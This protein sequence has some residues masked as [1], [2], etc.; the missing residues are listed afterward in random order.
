L[1]DDRAG[2]FCAAGAEHGNLHG[3]MGNHLH[4]TAIMILK[5]EIINPDISQEFGFGRLFC[6]SAAERE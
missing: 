5:T 3:A 2:S 1:K 6:S 4:S